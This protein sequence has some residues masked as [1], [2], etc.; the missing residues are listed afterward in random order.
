[1]RYRDDKIIFLFISS[2]ALSPSPRTF[3]SSNFNVP[4]PP[5]PLLLSVLSYPPFRPLLPPILLLLFAPPPAPN[6]HLRHYYRR[7]RARLYSSRARWWLTVRMISGHYSHSSRTFPNIPYRASRR[8]R[9]LGRDL[10]LAN[11]YIAAAAADAAGCRVYYHWHHR[12]GGTGRTYSRPT[13]STF[14]S[15]WRDRPI[16]PSIARLAIRSSMPPNWT[17]KLDHQ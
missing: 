14:R 9:A 11:A 7:R 10:S 5:P 17:T 12:A 15:H 8:I 6:C 3:P 16:V 4:P 13:I 2:D 1:M